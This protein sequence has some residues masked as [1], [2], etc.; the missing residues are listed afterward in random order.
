MASN[1]R[2]LLTAGQRVGLLGGSFNPAHEG[3]LHVASAC[4][5]AL[6]LDRI[7]FLV[8]PQNPLKSANGMEPLATRLAETRALVAAQ[9]DRRII[10]TDIETR[11]GTTRTIDTLRALRRQYPLVNFVW[12]MGADNMVQFTSW[13]KWRAITQTVPIAVYPRPG[14]TLKARLSPAAMVLRPV[15]I[16]PCDASLLPH[17]AAPALTFLQGRE[18]AASATAIRR[19]RDTKA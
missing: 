10:V 13:A 7:W 1:G 14:F 5:K 3:H 15:T 19:A 11:L 12:L 9:G 6:H 2:P 16:E 8:S 4:L 18:H 17:L